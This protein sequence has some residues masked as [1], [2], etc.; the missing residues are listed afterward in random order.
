MKIIVALL[1]VALCGGCMVKSTDYKALRDRYAET[2]TVAQQN[3]NMYEAE[4]A[5][6]AE[7]EAQLADLESALENKDVKLSKLQSG[8][9]ATP[10]LQEVWQEL[11]QLAGKHGDM[12]WDGLKRRL[13]ISVEFDLGS[14]SLKPKGKAAV[15]DVAQI[16]KKVSA[17][18]RIYIDGHIDNL[19]V[20]N[21]NTIAKF[22]DNQ[23]LSAARALAVYRV[24]AAEGVPGNLIIH[25]GF[26]DNRP[27]V[28][29][30]TPEGRAKNRRV[31]ISIF[32]GAT[33]KS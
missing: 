3:R 6:A 27:I 19:P 13:I 28:S 29:N 21:P 20:K 7:L 5:R 26:G 33:G 15:K 4:R 1:A 8:F 10:Q 32:P 9:T 2:E 12:M 30:D 24:L 23:E 31:E 22:K 16:L 25:R 11:E 17:D 18:N 14:D